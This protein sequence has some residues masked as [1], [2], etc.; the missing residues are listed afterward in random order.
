MLR[1]RHHARNGMMLFF[2][3]SNTERKFEIFTLPLDEI[4]ELNKTESGKS[5]KDSQACG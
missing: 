4:N 1:R 5:R 3:I 2:W